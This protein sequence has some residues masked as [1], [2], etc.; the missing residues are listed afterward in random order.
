MIKIQ[1]DETEKALIRLCK[2][3]HD[4]DK[5]LELDELIKLFYYKH[6]D[7]S[8]EV[9]WDCHSKE[10][11]IMFMGQTFFKI[12]EPSHSLESV[13]RNLLSIALGNNNFRRPQNKPED[14]LIAE[15]HGLIQWTTVCKVNEHGERI[16]R[17]D[18]D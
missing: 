15:L 12:K 18:I 6:W 4:F 3:K 17:F 14:R 9:P 13:T 7:L 5:N 11:F 16:W 2:N 8:D 1:L 10:H